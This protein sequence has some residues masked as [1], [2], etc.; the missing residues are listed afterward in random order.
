LTDLAEPM[1]EAE[2]LRFEMNQRGWMHQ[3]FPLVAMDK[4]SYQRLAFIV[5]WQQRWDQPVA[6]RILR[7]AGDIRL[8]ASDIYKLQHGGYLELDPAICL[9]DPGEA[10]RQIAE[11]STKRWGGLTSTKRASNTPD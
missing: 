7:E 4:D 8:P 11:Y 9:D 1:A 6:V 2:E 5:Y 10:L 3:F